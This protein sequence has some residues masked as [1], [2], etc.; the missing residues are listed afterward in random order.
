M[1]TE[2]YDLETIAYGTAGWNGI[3]SANAQKVDNHLHSRILVTLGEDVSQYDALSPSKDGDGKFYKALANIT[4]QPAWGLAAEAGVAAAQI[5]MQRIGP[6]T[7]AGWAWTPGKYIYL[8]EST[9]GA[10]TQTPPTDERARQ[11][12][13]FAI[14][15]TQIILNPQFPLEQA[16]TTTTTTTSTT[17]TTTTTATTST[18]STTTTTST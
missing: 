12:V 2:K 13:G 6:V 10:L 11:I 9:P 1:T 8:S 14:S 4:R 18:S 3:L 16:G 17:T 15:A 7:N 5:R